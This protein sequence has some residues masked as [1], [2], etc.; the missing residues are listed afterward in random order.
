M[1]KKLKLPFTELKKEVGDV[2]SQEELRT[3]V[4]GYD[5]TSQSWDS[6]EEYWNNLYGMVSC[7]MLDNFDGSSVEI[8]W[9]MEY[10]SGS[11]SGAFL[12]F[13][14]FGS[15][16]QGYLVSALNGSGSSP[17]K[18]SFSVNGSSSSSG[19]SLL[20]VTGSTPA[21]A[22]FTTSGGDIFDFTA[23]IGSG[24]VPHINYTNANG[25]KSTISINPMSGRIEISGSIPAN[26][27]I[28]GLK[29]AF[30]F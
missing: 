1:K 19:W 3:I 26:L 4:G 13:S 12:L 25:L 21:P 5:D 7:G 28:D 15:G 11:G 2:I 16:S 6:E 29:N 17:W 23:P 10:G 30:R 8:A 9:D 22:R 18:P 20:P 27:I 24:G 14:N